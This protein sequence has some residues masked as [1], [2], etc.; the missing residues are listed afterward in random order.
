MRK[1]APGVAA[2]I[3][4]VVSLTF[5]FARGGHAAPSRGVADAVTRTEQASSQKFAIDVRITRDS[6]PLTLHIHGQ[7][8]A[9]TVSLRLKLGDLHLADGTVVP[10]PDGAL[11]IDGPFLYERAPSNVGLQGNVKWLRLRLDDLGKWQDDLDTVRSMLPARILH[12]VDA[13]GFAPAAEDA[14]VFHGR[15]PYDHPSMRRLAK[16]TRNTEFRNVQVAATVGDD[17]L[18]HRIVLTGRTADGASTF[19]LRAHLF[20][21][22]KALHVTPPAPGTFTDELPPPPA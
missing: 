19:S 21:F 16:L 9:S 12:V 11:I 4:I 18:V 13:A 22:G 1:L 7:A 8:S 10:G 5:A 2:A 15:V 20:A 6:M 17:G 3:L 14:H